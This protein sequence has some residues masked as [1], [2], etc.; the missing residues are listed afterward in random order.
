MT[1][2]QPSGDSM[3][4]FIGLILMGVAVLWIAFCGLCA[5]GV[6][7]TVFTEA[8]A[9]SDM[10]SSLLIVFLIAGLGAAGGYAVFV[11]GRSLWRA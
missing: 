5:F 3:G 7:T 11:A 1:E 6:L 8:A 10:L 4:R 9:T 2:Q